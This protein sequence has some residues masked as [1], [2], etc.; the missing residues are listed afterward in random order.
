VAKKKK[1]S[2]VGPVN[3]ADAETGIVKPAGELTGSA[4]AEA[5]R[6][7]PRPVA[8]P[9]DKKVTTERKVKKVDPKTNET[10]EVAEHL[11]EHKEPVQKRET[12]KRK[13]LVLGGQTVRAP[14]PG[15][16]KRGITVVPTETNPTETRTRKKRV[17]KKTVVRDAKT[18]RARPKTK[19]ELTTVLPRVEA[20]APERPRTLAPGAG[21]QRT[22]LYIDPSKPKARLE[23]KDGKKEWVGG[24]TTRRLKG[25]AVPHKVIAPAVNQALQHLDNMAATRGTTEHHSH[26]EA[27]NTIHPTILG[28]DTRI[29]QALG[30]M[31]NHVMHPKH[32]S[33]SV[34]TQIRLGIADRLSEGKKM[35][36]QRAQRQGRT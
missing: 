33:S 5:E 24:Q 9:K 12:P 32:N 18:G 36:T 2:W 6:M 16:L 23:E 20:P 26:L 25:L 4:R 8:V 17:P 30:V 13:P 35:E 10:Y 22:P 34:I 14:K 19:D 11:K 15:E 31:H 1:A 29:H 27:F 7:S 3:P 21:P 28:M